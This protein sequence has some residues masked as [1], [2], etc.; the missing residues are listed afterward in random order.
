[1]NV[2]RRDEV[3]LLEGGPGE[4]IR[5][6]AGLAR[7]NSRRLSLAEVTV[8]PG[9]GSLEHY[10]RHTE[11]VYYLLRGQAQLTVGDETRMV[12]AG[13]TIVIPP[14]GRHKIVNVGEGDLILLAICA[15]A[16]HPEDSIYFE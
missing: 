2:V 9:G 8:G 14:G 15:P 3:P 1:V 11:E 10:H 4:V 16:W 13:D 5:E 12:G 7:G 6:L